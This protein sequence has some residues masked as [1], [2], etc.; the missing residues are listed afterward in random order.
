[1]NSHN[2]LGMLAIAAVVVIVGLFVVIGTVMFAAMVYAV[3][4]LTGLVATG[5]LLRVVLTVGV[6]ALFG[7]VGVCFDSHD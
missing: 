1:M 5:F 6:L 3:W 2:V 7:R 4:Y